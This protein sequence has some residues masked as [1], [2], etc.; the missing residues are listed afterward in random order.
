VRGALRA[1]S[2]AG[3][4]FAGLVGGHAIGYGI[5]VPDAHHRSTLYAETGHGY[6]PSFSWA[7]AVL[8]LAALVAGVAGGYVRRTPSRRHRLTR[9]ALAMAGA[10]AVAFVL[11]ETFERL[12]AD[13]PLQTLSPALLTIGIAVQLVVGVLAALLLRGL[14]KLGAALRGGVFVP[15]V[16]AAR[17]SRLRILT[18]ANVAPAFAANQVR[19]PP[20]A[21]AA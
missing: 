4:A 13:V 10:Q 20:A 8:G 19:G 12:A 16:V 18:R 1:V 9:A 17:S 3:L 14:R 15:A 11:V 21:L 7:A 6:L 2:V 5:A